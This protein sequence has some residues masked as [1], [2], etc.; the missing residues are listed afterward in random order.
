MKTLTALLLATTSALAADW[1]FFRG[2]NRN[3]ILDE[4]LEL[5]PGGPKKI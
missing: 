1:P 4:K 2:P 3:G 5:L